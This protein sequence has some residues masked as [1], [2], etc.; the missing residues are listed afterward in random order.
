MLWLKQVKAKLKGVDD[1]YVDLKFDEIAAY[2]Q[3][4]NSVLGSIDIDTETAWSR[5]E[6]YDKVRFE[7][8]EQTINLLCEQA[9]Q[10]GFNPAYLIIMVHQYIFADPWQR[11]WDEKQWA[12]R[13]VRRKEV[14]YFPSGW[15]MHALLERMS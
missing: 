5:G 15:A 9:E 14:D 7:K 11:G 10:R 6:K 1:F 8:D 4:F 3:M 12:K 2:Q 13:V